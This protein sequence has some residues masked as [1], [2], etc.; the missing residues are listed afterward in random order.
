MIIYEYTTLKNKIKRF[1]LVGIL[2]VKLLKHLNWEP[3]YVT[4]LLKNQK[5][6]IS[7]ALPRDL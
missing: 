2:H 5:Q 3:R 6:A 7:T 4:S 1:N